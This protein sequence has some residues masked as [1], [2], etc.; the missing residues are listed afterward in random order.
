MQKLDVADN[1]LCSLREDLS[2][3]RNLRDL[4]ANCNS[5]PTVPVSVFSRMTALTSISLCEQHP[6]GSETFQ[7]SSSLLPMLHAGL[8]KLDL[9]QKT[10]WDRRSLRNIR[11]AV[12]KGADKAPKL[13]VGYMPG[14]QK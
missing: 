11:R 4:V 12:D 14:N 13:T 7:V 5:F 2:R 1:K 9:S 3:L 6:E 10:P 8:V